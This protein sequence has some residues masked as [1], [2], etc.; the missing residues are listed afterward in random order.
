MASY[1]SVLFISV[2]GMNKCFGVIL[3]FLLLHCEYT[4]ATQESTK[5]PYIFMIYGTKGSGRANIALRLRQKFS[6][7]S[8]SIAALLT[9]HVLEETDL[10]QQVRAYELREGAISHHF[11]V[12]VLTERLLQP[13][14]SNGI[15]FDDFPQT[16]QQFDELQKCLNDHFTFHAF[17][18]ETSDQWLVQ[19]VKGRLVCRMCGRVFDEFL[20]PPKQNATCDVCKG[21]LQ[22]RSIDSPE[23]VT[24]QAEHYRAHFAPLV[25]RYKKDITVMH[26]NGDRQIDAIFNEISL[27]IS[28][29]KEK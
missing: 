12:C 1:I 4:L 3:T 13:D 21:P 26:I 7:P 24:Q 22:K 17:V 2:K 10:G 16:L 25:N 6:F 14:C 8:I 20:S 29:T 27:L 11:G 5:R 9:D 23:A 19:R 28:S 15:L 18:I